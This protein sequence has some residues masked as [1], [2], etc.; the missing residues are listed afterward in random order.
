MVL[1]PAGFIAP[2]AHK[3]RIIHP[4]GEVFHTENI[5]VV[6]DEIWLRIS[7]PKAAWTVEIHGL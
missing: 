7:G 2:N 4:A 3:R 1:P 5:V 6:S